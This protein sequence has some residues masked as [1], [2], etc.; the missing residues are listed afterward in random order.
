MNRTNFTYLL[1]LFLFVICQKGLSQPF[2]TVTFTG[3][4]YNDFNAN[5]RKN[6]SGSLFYEMTWDASKLYLGVSALYS[7]AKDQPTIYYL[8]TDPQTNPTTGT[9]STTGFNNYDGRI[10]TLPFTANVVIFLKNGYCE[11]RKYSAGA[12]G[13]PTNYTSNTYF[14]TNDAEVSIPWTDFPS[15]ARPSAFRYMMFK[16]NGNPGTDAYDIYPNGGMYIANINTTPF[17]SNAFIDIYDTSSG[18]TANTLIGN[19]PEVLLQG[20]ACLGDGFIGFKISPYLGCTFSI[21]IKETTTN[22]SY[23]Y[24]NV[25]ATTGTV[26][27]TDLYYAFINMPGTS[28]TLPAGTYQITNIATS[29]CSPTLAAPCTGF[30]FSGTITI[31]GTNSSP[32]IASTANSTTVSGNGNIVLNNLVPNRIYTKVTYLLNGNLVT[33]NNL[34]ASATG[35]LTIPNLGAG[36][37]TEITAYDGTCPSGTSMTSLSGP[38]CMPNVG[39]FPWDGN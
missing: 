38:T 23:T 34:T 21:T 15:G 9:G 20:G 25:N 17:S 10:G 14:G 6:S 22:T 13:A 28:Y 5:E 24:N 2:R 12:W 32:N 16:E 18:K 35:T 37:Y 33:K 4:A 8:D 39:T 29:V 11:M 27:G 3:D 19:C 36:T 31:D 26:T 7:Y 1:T 30:D